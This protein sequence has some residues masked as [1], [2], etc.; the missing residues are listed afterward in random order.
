MLAFL[1]DE[2]RFLKLCMMMF[3]VGITLLY[4]FYYLWHTFKVTMALKK[5]SYFFPVPFDPVKFVF[6]SIMVAFDFQ[7]LYYITLNNN[8]NVSVDTVLP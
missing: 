4:E 3:S 5:L 7:T 1:R 6:C 8:Y 2:A